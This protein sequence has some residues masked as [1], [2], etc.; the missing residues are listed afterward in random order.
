MNVRK[1]PTGTSNPQTA[2][3]IPKQP[4]GRER[5]HR[6]RERM[7]HLRLPVNKS[8]DSAAR[9]NQERTVIVFRQT[10]DP[11]VLEWQW[12]EPGRTRFP[13]PQPGQCPHPEIAAAVFVQANCAGT[14]TTI[15]SV[16]LDGALPNRAE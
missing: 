5:P 10:L 1:A 7:D 9:G 15:L 11:V 6:R 4:L 12:I 16:A 2:I 3:A 14:R 8:S 13:S